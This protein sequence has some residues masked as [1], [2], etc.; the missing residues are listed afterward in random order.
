VSDLDDAV[1]RIDAHQACNADSF[2]GFPINYGMK[3]RIVRLS[4]LFYPSAVIRSP[5]ERTVRQIGPIAAFSIVAIGVKQIL[6]MPH[7]I[8]RLKLT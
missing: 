7:R 1:G 5:I 2:F 4:N 6:G 8:E 3:E